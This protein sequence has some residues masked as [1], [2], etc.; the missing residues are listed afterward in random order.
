MIK[1]K[2]TS[3]PERMRVKFSPQVRPD[4]LFPELLPLFPELLPLFPPVSTAESPIIETAQ[5]L[6]PFYSRV[7]F[8]FYRGFIHFSGSPEFGNR[9]LP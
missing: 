8:L 3:N 2:G 7:I 1:N 5:P 9:K 4:P 6:K